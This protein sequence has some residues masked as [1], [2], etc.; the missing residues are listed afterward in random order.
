[1]SNDTRLAA[2]HAD[3]V[4]TASAFFDGVNRTHLD[5]RRNNLVNF[6]S[7]LSRFPPM[8]ILLRYVP[9]ETLT[10]IARLPYATTEWE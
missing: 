9:A 8:A 10:Q 4:D 3:A 7:T 2:W 5:W 6:W 1:M